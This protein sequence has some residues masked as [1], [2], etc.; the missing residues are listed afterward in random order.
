MKKTQ[1]TPEDRNMIMMIVLAVIML[2]SIA[3][4]IIRI[5]QAIR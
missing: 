3:T 1:L 5:V 4:N 2:I